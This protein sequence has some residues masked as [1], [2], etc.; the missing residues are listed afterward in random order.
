MKGY[1]EGGGCCYAGSRPLFEL[2]KHLLTR[3]TALSTLSGQP[4]WISLILVFSL[5]SVCLICCYQ[6]RDASCVYSRN[7]AILTL[8]S[9]QAFRIPLSVWATR[10]VGWPKAWILNSLFLTPSLSLPPS[11]SLSCSLTPNPYEVNLIYHEMNLNRFLLTAPARSPSL[12]K[13]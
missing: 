9:L 11:F 13:F 7:S 3:F 10:L 6:L 1:L 8:L 5:G 12:F 2:V 4:N